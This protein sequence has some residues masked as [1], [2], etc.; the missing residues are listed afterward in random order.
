MVHFLITLYVNSLLVLIKMEYLKSR[1]K[2]LA[3]AWSLE[4]SLKSSPV[5]GPVICIYIY[6]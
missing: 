6:V 5:L 1:G 3:K 2:Y 4:S